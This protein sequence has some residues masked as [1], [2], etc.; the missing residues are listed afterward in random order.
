MEK[1]VLNELVFLIK[2]LNNFKSTN[3]ARVKIVL[4]FLLILNYSCFFQNE[5]KDNK[6]IK[7]SL[8]KKDFQILR[9]TLE[10]AH[11]GLYWYSDT[12]ELN[13]FFDSTYTALDKDM[14]PFAFF[15]MLL[16]LIAKVKCGHTNVRLSGGSDLDFIFTKILPFTFYSTKGKIYITNDYNNTGHKGEEIISIN[17]TPA[18][19]IIQRILNSLPADG[20][21]ETYKYNLLSKGAFLEGYALYFGESETFTIESIDSASLKPVSFTV[22]AMKAEALKGK[23]NSLQQPVFVNFK[24]NNIAILTINSFI[25]KSKEFSDSIKA[26]LK[27][28]REKNIKH[29]IIDLRQNGGEH[30]ENIPVLF[31]YLATDSFLHLK[32]AEMNSGNFTYSHFFKNEG[33]FKN[34]RGINEHN[35][36]YVMNYRYAGTSFKQP[37]KD[38]RFNGNVFYF[39]IRLYFISGFRICCH[40]QIQ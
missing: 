31:S 22:K 32:R 14:T 2:R 35:G 20:F 37:Q 3:L 38:Y 6:Q 30:N 27:S 18:K 15:K 12:F 33:S 28:I 17:N 34:L 21:N 29:L 25:I 11:P 8:L 39:N 9:Q 16:P 19:E 23:N 7:S 4:F 26:I 40:C 5:N 13:R 36:K 10:E 24:S 1:P